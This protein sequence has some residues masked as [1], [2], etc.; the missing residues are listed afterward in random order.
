M[1]G[2]TAEDIWKICGHYL[3]PALGVPESSEFLDASGF[4][5]TFS[6]GFSVTSF[7]WLLHD[8]HSEH[9]HNSWLSSVEAGFPPSTRQGMHLAVS[10]E[11]PTLRRVEFLLSL[12]SGFPVDA[13]SVPELFDAIG[14]FTD[15]ELVETVEVKFTAMGCDFSTILSSSF[16]SCILCAIVLGQLIVLEFLAQQ[17]ELKWLMLNT[18]R[19][20]S[21]SSRVKL[22]LVWM[23]ASWCLVSMY[24][25][26]ILESRVIVSNNQSKRNSVGPWHVSHCVTPAFYYHLNHGII[27]LKDIQQSSGIRMCHAWWNVSDPDLCLWLDFIFA[28]LTEELQIGITSSSVEQCETEVCFLHI[29]LNGTNVWLPKMHRIPPD[30]DFENSRSLAKSGS[31]NNPSLHCCAV[32]PT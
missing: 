2:T 29:Q 19:R 4:L 24:P 6:T 27:V 21:H 1:W 18:W 3:F 11:N 25:I 14:R 13:V 26:W 10:H 8:S 30:V 32:F 20:L 15:K 17:V 28:C 16:C 9:S 22:P 31:W 7:S 23:S 12:A 5:V